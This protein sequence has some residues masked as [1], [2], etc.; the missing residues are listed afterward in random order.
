MQLTVLQELNYPR[1][2]NYYLFTLFVVS[3]INN[4]SIDNSPW[5]QKKKKYSQSPGL[6][7]GEWVWVRGGELPGGGGV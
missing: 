1:A 7:A 5:W 3:G 6:R 4:K 2:Q